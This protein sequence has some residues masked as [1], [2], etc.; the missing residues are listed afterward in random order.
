VTGGELNGMISARLITEGG[1][2]REVR[3]CFACDGMS[4]AM[5]NGFSGMAW[6]THRADLNALAVAV[7]KGAACMIFPA[8]IRPEEEV[9]RRAEAENMPLILSE[10]P[11]FELAGLL[12][13]AGLRG[14]ETV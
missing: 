6:I 10:K 13:E 3:G 1:N 9:I 7:M 8:G 5:A 4:F 11:A 14:E 12:Y 2:Q